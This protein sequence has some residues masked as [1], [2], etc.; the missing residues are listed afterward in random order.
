LDNKPQSLYLH[1]FGCKVYVYLL[2]EVCT[3]KLVL[4]SELMICIKYKDNIYCFICHAQGNVIFCSIH[5]IFDEEFFF[6]YTGSHAK[7]YKLYDYH[8]LSD[9][10]TFSTLF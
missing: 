1:I 7:E 4:Y 8:I 10:Y 6:K 3:N 9:I 5:V 2:N